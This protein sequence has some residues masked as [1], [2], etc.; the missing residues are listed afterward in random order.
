MHVDGTFDSEAPSAHANLPL[1]TGVPRYGFIG[2]GSEAPTFDGPRNN[3]YFVGE[4][5]EIRLFQGFDNI[6][7]GVGSNRRL[8]V[9]HIPL[10]E[11]SP[12]PDGRS[13]ATAYRS[14]KA[15]LHAARRG[16]QIWV[17]AGTHRA[18]NPGQVLAHLREQV[19][20]YGGFVGSET[21][22]DQRPVLQ[23]GEQPTTILDG[24]FNGD[25]NSNE[26]D[27]PHI[28]VGDR[29][30]NEVVVDG[31]TLR[32]ATQSAL[33][34]EGGFNNEVGDLTVTNTW[35]LNNRGTNGGAVQLV[36]GPEP[37]FRN[38]TFADNHAAR[39]GAIYGG[40]FHAVFDN[41]RFDNNTAQ[42]GGAMF[43]ERGHAHLQEVTF[44][45][46]RASEAGGAI[47]IAESS[48]SVS[49]DEVTFERN[50]AND[51]GG[52]IM[53]RRADKS[54]FDDYTWNAVQFIGNKS[55]RE[56]GALYNVE[57]RKLVLTEAMFRD[58]E[59]ESSSGGAI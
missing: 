9:T 8:H 15:A 54:Y 3:L 28:L 16:D 4:I 33:Y 12:Q 57:V 17:Q 24:D 27:S 19:S 20:L 36:G 6:G 46:N 49:M 53:N 44:V 42:L 1:G 59:S 13:W 52:A 58:N 37:V 31:F 7:I 14:I 50:R 29:S 38:V 30:A 55:S 5:D 48:L 25:G 22:L 23:P 21:E 26:D 40:S 32:G 41:V 2:D 18:R 34:I 45:G 10:S 39:G 47:Y 35:F 51:S 43:T 56:G 11:E